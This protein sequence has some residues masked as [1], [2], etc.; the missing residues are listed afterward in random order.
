MQSSSCPQSVYFYTT[1]L[2][3]VKRQNPVAAH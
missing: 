3:L 2:Y 1:S